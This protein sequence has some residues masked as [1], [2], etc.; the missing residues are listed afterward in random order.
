MP[1]SPHQQIHYG[2]A[3]D[4]HPKIFDYGITHFPPL[5]R[6]NRSRILFYP[7][8]FNS[9]H[10]GHRAL[11]EHGFGQNGEDVN[12]IAAIILPLDDE[13]LGRKVAAQGGTPVLTKA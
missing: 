8:S 1:L 7:G 13:S 6:R 9:L 10:R 4:F 5:L 3:T 2:D 11:L 12:I